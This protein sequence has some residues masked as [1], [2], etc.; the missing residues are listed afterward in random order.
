M[1]ICCLVKFDLIY[2][3]SWRGVDVWGVLLMK[4]IKILVICIWCV[5]NMELKFV[6][7]K[8][9]KYVVVVSIFYGVYEVVK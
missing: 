5:D 4:F 8:Y 6:K 3:Y 1:C 2:I 7:Y 9:G